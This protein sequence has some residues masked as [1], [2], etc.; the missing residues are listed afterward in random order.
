[1]IE[2]VTRI[3]HDASHDIMDEKKTIASVH[4]IGSQLRTSQKS[5]LLILTVTTE[6]D[7]QFTRLLELIV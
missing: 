4:D 7:A 5:S 3:S 6:V 2:H 1:M